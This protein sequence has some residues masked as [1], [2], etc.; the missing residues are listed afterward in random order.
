MRATV[1]HGAGD[2]R[3]ED[4][5]DLQGIAFQYPSVTRLAHLSTT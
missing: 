3:L 4:V 2:I 1:L 5:A